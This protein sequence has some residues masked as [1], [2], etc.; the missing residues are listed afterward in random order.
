MFLSSFTF[1]QWSQDKWCMLLT[2]MKK[3]VLIRLE[4]PGITGMDRGG[5]KKKK[6][7]L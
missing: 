1:I 4:Y 2:E 6:G 7:Q 5:V 3:I